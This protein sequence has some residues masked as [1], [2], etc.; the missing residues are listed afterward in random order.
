MERGNLVKAVSRLEVEVQKLIE[1]VAELARKVNEYVEVQKSL[2]EDFKKGY[3]EDL[4]RVLE[5][6]KVVLERVQM[7]PKVERRV[8]ADESTDYKTMRERILKKG[9]DTP[10]VLVSKILEKS[11]SPSEVVAA[12]RVISERERRGRR[13]SR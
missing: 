7:Q 5:E 10:S 3:G 13:V 12:L 4:R 11:V 1:G 6:V 9:L 8:I 2:H